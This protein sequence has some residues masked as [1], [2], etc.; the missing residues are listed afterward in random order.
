M[1][2]LLLLLSACYNITSMPIGSPAHSRS[3]CHVR[4]EQITPEEAGQRYRQVGIIC[5]EASDVESGPE[6]SRDPERWSTDLRGDFTVE[7]CRLGGDVV[8]RVD[9]CPASVRRGLP[10]TEFA[11]Y[12]ERP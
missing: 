6:Y 2:R 3:P 5:V 11:V 4:V 8:V 10:G 7:A 9:F 12:R 1:K